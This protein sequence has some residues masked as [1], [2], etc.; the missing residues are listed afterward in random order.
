VKAEIYPMHVVDPNAEFRG[1]SV[2]KL[3][4]RAGKEACKAILRKWKNPQKVQI[5]C[6]GGNNGGDGFALAAEFLAKKI[7]IEVILAVPVNKIR[8]SAAQHHFKRVPKKIIS[9]FSAKTKFDGDILV[10]ALLG[11]GVAGSL[12]KPFDTIVQKLMKA[13]GNLV[14]LDI[15]TSPKLKPKLVIAFHSSKMKVACPERAKQIERVVPIGIPKIAETHFGPGDV[16][17]YFPQ[18]K[19]D[20]HKG[21]NGR[22]VVVGGSKNFVG[23]PLFAG[24]GAIASGVD[25][26]DIFVP[27]INFAA[28]RKFSPNFLI[29]EISGEPNFLTPEAAVEILSFAKKNN[30]TLVI[31]PGLGRQKETVAAI[32]FLARNCRQ[33]LVFDADALIPN[34]PKFVSKKVVLT[35]HAGEWRRIPKN[36]N[37]TILKKGRIDEIIAPDGR[38]RWNDQGNPILTV[39][40]TGDVLAGVVG[41]LLAR[42]VKPF[43]AAGIAA[44]LVGLTGEQ[45]AVKSESTTPQMLARIIPKIIRE[46]LKIGN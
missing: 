1:V 19:L 21:E 16:K 3:M 27:K 6:G 45:I 12:K 34:L 41:G 17:V 38:R 39:G 31:G 11:I 36:L 24:L 37:A 10:D 2:T 28:S 42:E 35:P 20:S 7:E 22:V 40:G 33:T 43:E 32:E 25:L 4:N 46:I 13:E 29:R 44:F 9:Q 26:V 30:A 18:R 8:T 23:A 15:A 14:S 5:F